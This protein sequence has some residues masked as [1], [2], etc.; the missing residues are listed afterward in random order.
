MQIFISKY[1]NLLCHDICL[2]LETAIDLSN[3]K[4]FNYNVRYI[5]FHMLNISSDYNPIV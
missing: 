3:L 5:L 2:Q 4:S 1:N